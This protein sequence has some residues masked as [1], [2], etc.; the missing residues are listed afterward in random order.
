VLNISICTQLTIILTALKRVKSNEISVIGALYDRTLR[1]VV[2]EFSTT[3]YLRQVWR[4][5]R[6]RFEGTRNVTL[7]H[8]QFDRMWTPD[9]FIRNLKSGSFHTI[10]V[11]NRLIRLSPDGTILYSQ[12]LTLTL[13]CDMMLIKYPMDN[14]T[15]R[16]EF[17][18]CQY[19]V[20]LIRSSSSG[21]SS[22]LSKKPALL[23]RFYRA[24][25]NA[26]AV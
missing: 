7:N 1:C 4:D 25:C 13:T 18:S 16:I 10:T 12:R 23:I 19:S 11:P 3:L 15:C 9:V 14:Q 26:D 22:R 24:A 2:Q 17:G 20:L 5:P 8:K 21:S 6:L